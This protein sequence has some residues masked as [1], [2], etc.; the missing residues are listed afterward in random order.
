MDGKWH[1]KLARTVGLLVMVLLL[2]ACAAPAAPTPTPTAKPAA[3]APTPQPPQPTAAAK[4]TAPTPTLAPLSPPATV[5]VA[6][7]GSI[8]DGAIYIA[9]EKGYFKEQGLQVEMS[10]FGTTAESIPLLG[11]EKMEVTRGVGSAGLFNAI[12]RGIPLKVVAD[13]GRTF[14]GSG[15]IAIV[16]QKELLDSGQ[17]KGFNDLKGRK[18]A[19]A[20]A[21]TGSLFERLMHTA[22]A[23]GNLTPKDATVSNLSM[24][25]AMSAMGSKSVDGAVLA[26]PLV[27]QGVD[28]G[29]FVRWQGLDD[30]LPDE[31]HTWL[32][33]APSFVEK[34]PEAAKRFMVAY[35]KGARAYMDAIKAGKDKDSVINI[36]TKYTSVKDAALYGKMVFP[37]V[38]PNGAIHKESISR[39][40]EWNT[41]QGYIT[42][43]LDI[44]AMIDDQFLKFALGQLGEVK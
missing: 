23:K 32:I 24:A 27:T 18:F 6:V 44:N 33:Y 28:R 8:G 10:V 21:G 5:R 9:Q 31:Q 19:V 3:Q 35:L 16:L 12:V 37:A 43:K 40:I 30:L 42:G 25:D 1:L 13:S 36:L 7:Y 22:L 38:D 29:I 2:V 4:A 15:Y 41:G 34:N 26:E 20:G 11:S 17:I 14:K 39:M